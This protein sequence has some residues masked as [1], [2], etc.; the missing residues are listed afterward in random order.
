M[1]TIKELARELGISP[2]TVSIVLNGKSVERKISKETQEKVI[3]AAARHGYQAN[4]AARRLKSRYGA[5]ELQI[6]IF[7]AQDFRASMMARFLEGVRKQLDEQGRQ[8]RLAVYPYESGKLKDVHALFSA[9]DCHAAIVG[10]ASES[11]LEYLKQVPP[12]IPTVLYNRTSDRFSSA[13][14]DHTQIGMLA[15]D[16]LADNGV[17]SACIVWNHSIFSMMDAR[18]QAFSAQAKKRGIEMIGTYFCNGSAM[19]SCGLMKSLLTQYGTDKIPDGIFCGSSMTAHGVLRALWENRIEIPTRIK[20]IGV[21]N[22]LEEDDECTIPSLS[23]IR[24]HMEKVAAECVKI[25]MDQVDGKTHGICNRV[26]SVEYV[27]RETCG[28]LCP[29]T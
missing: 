15:A 2:S 7:W 5:D 28:P 23:V 19:D 27:P 8:V 24:I 25:L 16:A 18:V 17:K 21:G 6:A 4:I 11:D 10:N 9:S 22:G 3:Q 29:F 26:F 14:M 12:I 20:L 1:I 13:T